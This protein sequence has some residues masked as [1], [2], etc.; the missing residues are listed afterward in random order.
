MSSPEKKVA[1]LLVAHG[2][3]NPD[4]NEQVRLFA[5]KLEEQLEQKITYGFIELAEPLLNQALDQI[6]QDESVEAVKLLPLFLFAA[7]HCKK[8]IPEAIQR[9]RA[10]FPGKKF[11][12]APALGVHAGMIQILEE[13]LR[14]IDAASQRQKPDETLLLMIG[15]GSSDPDANSEFYKL[16]RLLWERV[17]FCELAFCFIDVTRPSFQEGLHFCSQSKAR[18]VIGVPYF[19]FPGVLMDRIKENFSLFKQQHPQVEVH[20]TRYLGN[21]PRVMEVL[22]D[23][24][25]EAT[26]WAKQNESIGIVERF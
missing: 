25:E 26:V 15:R 11:Y 24:A 2:S 23:R 20:L 22:L 12:L 5:R 17:R 14:Q 16:G 7:G 18:R 6:C 9:A 1:T 19:L 3:R 13:T 21:H 8:D 10:K 4:G